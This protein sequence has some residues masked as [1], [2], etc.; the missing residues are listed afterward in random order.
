MNSLQMNQ[1][2]I[3]YDDDQLNVVDKI[4]TAL[5]RHGLVLVD[6]GLLHD[7]YCLFTLQAVVKADAPAEPAGSVG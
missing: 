6:D 4:N 2:R 1:V 5:K 7:G 3:E